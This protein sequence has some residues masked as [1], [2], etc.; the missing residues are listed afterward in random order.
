MVSRILPC[1]PGGRNMSTDSSDQEQPDAFTAEDA[2]L[3]KPTGQTSASPA[4][5]SPS[6]GEDG[7]SDT[8][9]RI[10]VICTECRIK[11]ELIKDLDKSHL[12]L[13][14]EVMRLRGKLQDVCTENLQMI[15]LNRKMADELEKRGISRPSDIKIVPG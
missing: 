3:G 1:T 11:A 7:S 6:S 2:R 15:A 9:E 10:A 14:N 12:K 4:D 5:A 13:A 8:P